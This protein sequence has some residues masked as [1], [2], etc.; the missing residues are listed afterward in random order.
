MTLEEIQKT[1]DKV[2]ERM[3]KTQSF[4]DLFSK[5]AITGD[6]DVDKMIIKTVCDIA[7]GETIRELN[8]KPTECGVQA[9]HTVYY[10]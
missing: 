10:D 1:A 6:K 8:I 5:L 3:E 9:I 7:V 2:W 4:I